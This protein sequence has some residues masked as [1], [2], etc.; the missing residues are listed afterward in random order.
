MD[1]P[2]RLPRSPAG[3]TPAERR[4]VLLAAGHSG[5]RGLVALLRAGLADP[6]PIVRREAAEAAGR[7]RRA[8]RRLLA[9]LAAQLAHDPDRLCREAAAFARGETGL[10]EAAT[11]LARHCAGEPETVVREA[12]AGALGAIGD[13]ASLPAL[14]ALARHDRP[15]VRRR[16]VV[17][18]SA[19]GDSE[20]DAAQHAALKDRNRGVREVA[21]WVLRP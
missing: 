10:P 6:A 21:R 17:A 19:F 1:S 15:G 4:R 8:C 12:V 18:L 9:E 20:A 5:G 16:A 14:L 7:H 11:V 13:P 3:D 2:P